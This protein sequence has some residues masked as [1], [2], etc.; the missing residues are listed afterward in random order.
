[1]TEQCSETGSS[2]SP[3]PACDICHYP[4]SSP[5]HTLDQADQAEGYNI[6]LDSFDEVTESSKKGCNGCKL[7]AQ[8][9]QHAVPV[10]KR[11]TD[12]RLIFSRWNDGTVE[13]F[14]F[15]ILADSMVDNLDVFTV[16]GTVFLS[17]S[18]NR[19]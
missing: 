8:I 18:L 3:R 9:W 6:E 15:L 7:L 4:S 5:T 17:S 13:P 2:Q 11:Q 14:S 10:E 12:S 1:M 19:H 16:H